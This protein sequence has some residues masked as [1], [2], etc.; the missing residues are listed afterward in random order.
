MLVLGLLG[1]FLVQVNMSY[2]PYLALDNFTESQ[3]DRGPSSL[4][5]SLFGSEAESA[6]GFVP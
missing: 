6:F 5:V 3:Q 4:L 1:G 2:Y